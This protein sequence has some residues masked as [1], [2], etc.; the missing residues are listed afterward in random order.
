M[1]LIKPTFHCRVACGLLLAASIRAPAL[2]QETDAAAFSR[3]LASVRGPGHLTAGFVRQHTLAHFDTPLLSSGTLWVAS[4]REGG[5][6]RIAVQWPYASDYV[7]LDGKTK[8]RSQHESKWTLT[9]QSAKPG[10]TAML[11]QMGAWSMGGV[12]RADLFSIK[13]G[14]GLIPARPQANELIVNPPAHGDTFLLT[15]INKDLAT[16]VK[17]VLLGFATGPAKGADGGKRMLLQYLEIDTVPGDSVKYW[18]FEHDVATPLPPD[19]FDP[20]KSQKPEPP[21]P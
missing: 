14:D 3:V 18:F 2:A 1:R 21:A 9:D 10:L 16:S 5:G 11:V 4:A 6:E 8:A 17:Q 13:R 15:A 19:V 20:E 7:F 12:G